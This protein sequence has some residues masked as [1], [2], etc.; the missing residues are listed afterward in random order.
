[1]TPTQLQA[2]R[3]RLG[4][5]ARGLAAALEMDGQWSDRTIRKWERGEHAVPGPVAVAVRYMVK[6]GIEAK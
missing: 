2:A 3:K 6:Y 5:S 1:M 4:L